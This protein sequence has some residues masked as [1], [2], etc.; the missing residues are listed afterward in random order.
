[1]NQCNNLQTNHDRKAN[2]L[3]N[4]IHELVKISIINQDEICFAMNGQYLN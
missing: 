2:E 4:N 1:M 3:I